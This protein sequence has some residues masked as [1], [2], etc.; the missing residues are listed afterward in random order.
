MEQRILVTDII[1]GIRL[2]DVNWIRKSPDNQRIFKKDKMLEIFYN[3]D[4]LLRKRGLYFDSRLNVC[5]NGRKVDLSI[6]KGLAII[7][8]LN[9]WIKKAGID[10]DL[11][12]RLSGELLFYFDVNFNL[13]KI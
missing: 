6:M 1:E 9:N 11:H 8:L 12:I 3:M 5:R 4:I 13:G 2:D 7:T 10:N